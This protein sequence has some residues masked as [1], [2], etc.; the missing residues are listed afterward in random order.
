MKEKELAYGRDNGF[1]VPENYF[2]DF[3][4]R[5]MANISSIDAEENTSTAKAFIVPE[6]Y[7]ESFENR[8]MDRLEQEAPKGKLVPLFSRKTWSYVAGVAAVLAVLLSSVVFNETREYDIEDLDMLA[9]ENYLLETFEFT[10]P[11]ETEMIN[12]AEFSF[13]TSASPNLDREAI[14]EYLQENVEETAI[15]LNE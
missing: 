12:E 1:R 15:L 2:R 13:A 5:M 14:L 4:A 10:N 8:M 7:F 11:E 3:E 9:V 6:G